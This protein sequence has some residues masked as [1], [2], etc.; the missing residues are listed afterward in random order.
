MGFDNILMALGTG[1]PSPSAPFQGA[2]T[3]DLD[4]YQIF[5]RLRREG[6][7]LQD[8]LRQAEEAETLRKRVDELSSRQGSD[9]E[10]FPVMEKAVSD[11]PDVVSAKDSL[12]TERNRVLS[13]LLMADEGFRRAHDEYRKTVHRVYVTRNTQ[14]SAD[15]TTERA[16]SNLAPDTSI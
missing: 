9:A 8:I 11:D 7:S 13:S 10:V 5:D 14:P 2:P 1:N 4:D 12:M 3:S 15:S 16:D 6:R